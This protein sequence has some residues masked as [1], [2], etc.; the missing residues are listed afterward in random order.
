MKSNRTRICEVGGTRVSHIPRAAG[1]L[2]STSHAAVVLDV[3]KSGTLRSFVGSAKE[4]K[5]EQDAS[6]IDET[7]EMTYH[8]APG[9]PPRRAYD[10]AHLIGWASRESTQADEQARLDRGQPLWRVEWEEEW[11]RCR[12]GKIVESCVVMGGL[13]SWQQS[14]DCRGHLGLGTNV[15]VD[16]KRGGGESGGLPKRGPG[17]CFGY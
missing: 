6:S 16:R 11:N 7:S 1:N 9:I 15:Q 12:K 10:L 4:S 8:S 5:C 17:K 2:E 3:F 14:R 13:Q